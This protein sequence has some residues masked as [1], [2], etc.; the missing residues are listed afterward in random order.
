MIRQDGWYDRTKP[1]DSL[2]EQ[3]LT[4]TLG[5]LAGASAEE[6]ASIRPPLPQV[7]LFPPRFGYERTE[8]TVYDC[9]S[10]PTRYPT[11]ERDFTHQQPGYSGS[12]VQSLGS[13]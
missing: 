12:S 13:M 4:A 5:E 10:Q 2:P 9:F 6:I 11:N 3:R 1:W 7:P 8:P